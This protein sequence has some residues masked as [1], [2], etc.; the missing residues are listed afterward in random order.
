MRTELV[1]IETET[2]PLDG[3][4]YLPDDGPVL[5]GVLL[6]H[7]NTMNFYVG[8]PRFL[9]PVLT[10]PRLR[11]PRLQPARARYPQHRATAAPRRRR[12]P[13]HA[14]RRSPTTHRRRVDEIARVPAPGRDRPQQRR[15]AR[16]QVCVRS[17]G[18]PRAGAAVGAS[19]RRERARVPAPARNSRRPHGRRA[20][21]EGA[22]ADRRRP[23]A[24]AHADARLVVRHQRRELRRPHDADARHPRA[25]A[26]RALP[27]AVQ[28][29]ATRSRRPL[30]WPRNS[31]P[32][33][34]PTAPSRSF[35]TAI[36]SMSAAR[37]PSAAWCRSGCGRR[38]CLRSHQLN[39][40]CAPSPAPPGSRRSGRCR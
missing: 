5:G 14:R 26:V 3:A 21:G 28:S 11:L 4:F 9:P 32:A 33:R 17:P 37:T 35:P 22:G 34:A 16:R 12:V 36:T 31:R 25:R 2:T 19:R 1:T 23:R 6:F 27:G 15:H 40:P 8:A 10:R 7:G 38:W 18:D 13:V 29:A 39:R 30:S 20:D 24:R